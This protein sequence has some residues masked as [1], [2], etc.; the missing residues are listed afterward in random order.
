MERQRVEDG[1]RPAA[2]TRSASAQQSTLIFIP[3]RKEEKEG[4]TEPG[5]ESIE[6]GDKSNGIFSVEEILVQSARFR[7]ISGVSLFKWKEAVPIE[8]PVM[9][10]FVDYPYRKQND[11][12]I[13]LRVVCLR[14]VQRITVAAQ[15]DECDIALH[16]SPFLQ[17]TYD[18]LV[19]G[20]NVEKATEN[21]VAALKLP[22]E[23]SAHEWNGF[24]MLQ[25]DA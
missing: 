12:P 5:S 13:E 7:W 24:I 22:P 23:L 21:V 17:T 20:L 25:S 2:F 1:C 6:L 4:T 15:E 19:I 14:N 9:S 18:G 11:F 10:P 8:R 16:S 3:C